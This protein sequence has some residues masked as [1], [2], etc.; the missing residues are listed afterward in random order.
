MKGAVRHRRY[1]LPLE[2]NLHSHRFEE[3]RASHFK[4]AGKY[5]KFLKLPFR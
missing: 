3:V 2:S 4:I 1:A 5:G